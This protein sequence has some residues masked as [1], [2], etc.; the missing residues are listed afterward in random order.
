MRSRD[1]MHALSRDSEYLGD[2]VHTYQFVGHIS[3]VPLTCDSN[4]D[5]SYSCH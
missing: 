2:L 3:T 4:D 5:S 1:D